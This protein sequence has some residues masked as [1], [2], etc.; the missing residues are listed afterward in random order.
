MP[1]SSKPPETDA[2]AVVTGSSS[3]IGRATAVALAQSGW[4]VSI[5]ARQNNGGLEETSAAIRSHGVACDSILCDIAKSDDC[6]AL[7]DQAFRRGPVRAWFNNAGADVL[8]GHA[9]DWDFDAKLQQLWRVDVLGTIRLSRLVG[10]RMKT[11]GGG[12]ILNMGWDQAETGMAG[13]S[14]E[15]FAA[16]KGAVMSFSR[17]LARSLAPTVRV[18]CLAPG[19]IRTAWSGE[20][21]GYWLERGRTESQL[22]RWGTPED[23][24]AAAVF[25]ASDQASFI[26]G[27]TIRVNG[28]WR[29]AATAREP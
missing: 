25:L 11:Q 12:V 20:A 17:S 29:G 7:V 18:N 19:W 27:Q 14:G 21:S 8:T 1:S 23:V 4:N 22:D 5:H 26:H 28:G 24:A 10:D 16:A 2:W 13:D 9:A 15:Y 6:D 3:G